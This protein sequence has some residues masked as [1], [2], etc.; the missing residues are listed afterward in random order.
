[1][2]RTARG[3]PDDQSDRR[4]LPGIGPGALMRAHGADEHVTVADLE[5]A[6]RLYVALDE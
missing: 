3:R 5:T 2:S 1:V 6:T 4:Y